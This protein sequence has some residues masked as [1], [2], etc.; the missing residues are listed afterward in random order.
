VVLFGGHCF[1][2]RLRFEVPHGFASQ[3]HAEDWPS[4]TVMS[5]MEVM[6]EFKRV[7]MFIDSE[8]CIVFLSSQEMCVGEGLVTPFA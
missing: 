6:Q 3:V 4:A 1:Y 7:V 2:V 8:L 5:F